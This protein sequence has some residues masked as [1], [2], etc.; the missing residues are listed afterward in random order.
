MQASATTPPISKTI[1]KVTIILRQLFYE[2]IRRLDTILGGSIMIPLRISLPSD[3]IR[4]ITM[5][6]LA[7]QIVEETLLSKALALVPILV[8][9]LV[10]A[11]G[12]A[13]PEPTANSRFT[14]QPTAALVY[15]VYVDIQDFTHRDVT[16]TVGTTIGWENRGNVRHTATEENEQ[17][18]SKALEPGETFPFTFTQAGTYN[19]FCAIYP[20]MRATVTVTAVEASMPT[21]S[22]TPD[23]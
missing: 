21:P 19:Y 22:P 1:S 3:N 12:D 18:D 10:A 4:S 17:W 23:S 14:Q 11:C 20:T 5:A 6:L 16:V 13:V 8:V 9:F 7:S 15:A 2:A